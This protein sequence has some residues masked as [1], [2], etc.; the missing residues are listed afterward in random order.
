MTTDL[1]LVIGMVL[2]ALAIPSILSAFSDGRAPRLAAIVVMIAGTLIV[3]AISRKP[4][5]YEIQEDSASLLSGCRAIDE[6]IGQ[7]SACGQLKPPLYGTLRS[8]RDRPKWHAES[9]DNRS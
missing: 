4:G 5:G 6:L 8:P 9:C 3:V 2:G 7:E 1:Y